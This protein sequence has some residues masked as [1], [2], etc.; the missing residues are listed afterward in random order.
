MKAARKL[1]VFIL[2]VEIFLWKSVAHEKGKFLN[3]FGRDKGE[4]LKTVN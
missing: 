2:F 3:F 1:V 4:E